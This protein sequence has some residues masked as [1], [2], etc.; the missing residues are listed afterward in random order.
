MAKAASFAEP[1]ITPVRRDRSVSGFALSIAL[2]AAVIGAFY[3]SI[4]YWKKDVVE[5]PPVIVD[6]V[7][8]ADLTAAPPKPTPKVDEQPPTPTPEPPKPTEEAAP[9]QDEPPPPEP[10]PQPPPPPPPKPEP[11]PPPPKVPPPPPKPQPPKKKDDM[12]QLEQLLKSMQKNQPQKPTEQNPNTAKTTN[13]QATA[14]SDRATMTELDAIR[15]HIEGC[16]R[17]DPGEEGIENL[18]AEIRVFINPDG[19]VQRADII[20]TA[21]LFTDRRFQTFANSARISVLSCKGIPITAQH[22]NELKE[23]VLNFS[24]QGRIN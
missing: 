20:D 1:V 17:V 7:E 4:P 18:S 13:N 14:T 12:A 24:P 2:H 15:T 5:N 3:L 22:Y 8:V 11:A 23:M 9:K 6:L 10:K 16:W 19:S 21:R